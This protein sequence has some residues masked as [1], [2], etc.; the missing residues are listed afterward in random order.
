MMSPKRDFNS[1]ILV[2]KEIRVR[3]Y[4]IEQIPLFIDMIQRELNDDAFG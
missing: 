4:E 2:E 3:T 1:V